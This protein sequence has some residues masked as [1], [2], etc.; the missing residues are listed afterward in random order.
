MKDFLVCTSSTG[1]ISKIPSISLC[2][3]TTH[4]ELP[5]SHQWHHNCCSTC[6]ASTSMSCCNQSQHSYSQCMPAARA[7]CA[8]APAAVGTQLHHVS[9]K[10]NDNKSTNDDSIL[11]GIES[12]IHLAH[13]MV[14]L[15]L[16]KNMRVNP[17]L[18]TG[19]NSQSHAPHWENFFVALLTMAVPLH[20]RYQHCFLI[21]HLQTSI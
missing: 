10:L 14:L 5:S 20:D 11:A 4:K 15:T 13:N 6:H 3:D 19:L 7:H 17:F 1:S 9:P 16:I 8:P 18:P 12:R 21:P 2:A